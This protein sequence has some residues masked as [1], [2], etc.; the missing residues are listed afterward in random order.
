MITLATRTII[1]GLAL[2]PVWTVLPSSVVVKP[3]QLN[4]VEV[5]NAPDQLQLVRHVLFE[6]DLRWTEK[7]VAVGA[8]AAYCETEGHRFY[9]PMEDG[10]GRSYPRKPHCLPPP[11]KYQVHMTHQM[12]LGFL[13]AQPTN[14]VSSP[15]V[16]KGSGELRGN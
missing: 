9:A 11:G 15:I 5:D 6:T 14:F 12:C 16:V 1:G 4:V 7:W 10:N 3:Q 2:V 13:C 8:Y